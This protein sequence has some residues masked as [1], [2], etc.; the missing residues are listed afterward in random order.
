MQRLDDAAVAAAL[1]KLPAWRRD[2]DHLR[3][4]FSF[5]DFSEAWGFMSR[6]ALSAEAMNHHPEWS[7]VYNSVSIG[8]STHDAGG[9]TELDVKLATAID[10]FAGEG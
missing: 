7:N 3:R 8:L 6:V 1:E 4:D 2:G 10:S 9:L 5:T